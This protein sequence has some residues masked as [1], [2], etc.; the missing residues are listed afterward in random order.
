MRWVEVRLR[1]VWSDAVCVRV[2]SG[3]QQNL[4]MP[5]ENGVGMSWVGMV[6]RWRYV[7]AKVVS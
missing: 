1:R 7:R 2:A 5:V 3:R 4:K 6:G